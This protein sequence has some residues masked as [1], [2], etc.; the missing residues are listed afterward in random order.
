MNTEA[1]QLLC[2]DAAN[3]YS[4]ALDQSGLCIDHPERARQRIPLRR[5]DRIVLRNVHQ[6]TLS[7]LIE[8]ARRGID[9]HFQNGHGQLLATLGSASAPANPIYQQWALVISHRSH[10][11]P[12]ASWLDHQLRHAASQVLKHGPRGPIE[13]FEQWLHTQFKRS[14]P[15][16]YER[17][18]NEI[19]AHLWAWLDSTLRREGMTAISESLQ[20]HGVDW[21]DDLRRC[22]W[23]PLRWGLCQSLSSHR[24]ISNRICVEHF[25]AQ[26]PT[27][28]AR[29]RLHL[30]AL[31]YSLIRSPVNVTP[32]GA[33]QP[34]AHE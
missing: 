5:I 18:D 3:G 14:H 16:S 25:E 24:V 10:I 17:I 12:Y 27:L 22:L 11:S 34:T 13:H 2:L 4:L 31:H 1:G 26:R 19:Y 8:I 32:A 6:P 23:I 33:R 20:A 15:H 28:E 30:S 7:H 29:L 21:Q 9:I